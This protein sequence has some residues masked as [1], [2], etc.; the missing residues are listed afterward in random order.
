MET[1]QIEIREKKDMEEITTENKKPKIIVVLGQTA[2]GKSDFAVSL[3][4]NLKGE[5]I[6]ADSR[7]VYKGLDIGTGKITKG[8]MKRIPHHLLD[9]VSPKKV[10][11]VAEWKEK[12]E[13][14]I[15]DIIKRKKVPIVC[16]GTGLYI[17]ALVD[18]ITFPEV[19][20]DWK[21]RASLE[22]KSCS[23]LVDI[24]NILVPNRNAAQEV[25]EKNPRRLIRAIEIANELGYLP[26]KT[27]RPERGYLGQYDVLQIG[28]SVPDPDLR[29]KIKKRLL[30]RMRQGLF[31][32]ASRLRKRGL[33]LKR[34]HELGLEY[35]YLALFL[36]NEIGK[37]AF[38]EELASAIWQYAK[39]QR[40]WFKKDKRIL[41]V[42]PKD[43]ERSV[44]LAR[45]FLSS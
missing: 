17:S 24:L 33:S 12:A 20:P 42:S 40:T 15:A 14:V 9:V 31:T 4:R 34:M 1:N 36:E 13:E 41:W 44:H 30:A 3:A 10:Y 6:S 28:L 21:L 18:N 35:H 8:E 26:E 45:I 27:E 38:T 29:K 43:T 5:I 2:T 11:S 7:Q 25:D 22:K 19:K 39:R 32:E 37:K 23:E 16:G